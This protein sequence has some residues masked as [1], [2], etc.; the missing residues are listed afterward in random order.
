MIRLPDTLPGTSTRP[1]GFTCHVQTASYS[2]MDSDSDLVVINP[3][4]SGLRARLPASGCRHGPACRRHWS[5]LIDSD[6]HLRRIKPYLPHAYYST[7][8]CTCGNSPE[9]PRQLDGRPS[10]ACSATSPRRQST[11]GN[12]SRPVI[13]I[14]TTTTP[15]I[16]L[17][18]TPCYWTCYHICYYTYID[19][20]AMS[21]QNQYLP[22]PF[23]QS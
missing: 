9:H 23:N 6:G 10:S 18:R 16:M 11:V 20:V 3:R 8:S 17:R 13:I 14:C 5:V 22:D 7:L 21:S 19:R 4:A 15:H 1:L 12:S 2:H